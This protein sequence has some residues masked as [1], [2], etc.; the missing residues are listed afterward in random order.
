MDL[1][2]AFLGVLVGG[3][4]T[5]FGQWATQRMESDRERKVGEREFRRDSLVSLQDSIERLQLAVDDVR[6]HRSEPGWQPARYRRIRLQVKATAAR[7]A[8]P[9]LETVVKDL[10][11]CAESA[12]AE[13]SSDSEVRLFNDAADAAVEKTASLL[14]KI[15]DES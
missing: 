6:D 9:D 12:T 13:S 15:H 14:A 10:L 1:D 4:I 11:A 2:G 8:D 7:F 3:A 5:I